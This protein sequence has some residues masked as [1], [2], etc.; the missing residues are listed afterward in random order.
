MGLT[1]FLSAGP[2][3]WPGT[4][5]DFGQAGTGAGRP[6]AAKTSMFSTERS[7]TATATGRGHTPFRRAFVFL[8]GLVAGT[9]YTENVLRFR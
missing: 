9:G 1:Q 7:R 2:A 8:G 6:R 4:G 5:P 3:Y